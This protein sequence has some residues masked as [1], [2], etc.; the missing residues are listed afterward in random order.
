VSRVDPDGLVAAVLLAFLATAGLFYVNIMAALVTGLEDGLR[1]TP[2]AAGLVASANVYGAA[3]GALVAVFLVPRLPWRRVAVAALVGL[4]AIDLASTRVGDAP[5]LT[6]VRALH[7]IVGGLLIGFAFAVIARTARPDRAFGMLLVVQFGLGGLGLW[8]LPPLVPARGAR[9]LFLALAA[10]SSVALIMLPFLPAYPPR[11]R[12]ALGT[13]TIAWG[14]LGATL[15]A[16]FLF[17]AGNMG[18]AGFVI[19]LGRDAG[20]SQSLIGPALAAANWIGALGSLCVVW[21]GARYGRTWPI[22][23]TTALSALATIGFV[24]SASA[25]VYIA[26]NVL[27]ALFWTFVIPYLLAL[28]AQ[29]DR[30]GQAA[31]LGGFASKLGLATGPLIASL[32]V[33]PHDYTT[34]I[35]ASVVMLALSAAIAF[36]PARLVDRATPLR[37]A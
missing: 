10:F 21:F 29:F 16:I 11:P 15:A 35:A 19:D 28:A 8:L 18:L 32:V 31:A 27:T 5:T 7:G 24:G 22:V 26:A 17:Q 14:P 3:A 2:R 20:L 6:A 12:A 4:I 30:A 36:T 33:R 23:A 25:P 37:T 1:F 9:V 34:L 13:A